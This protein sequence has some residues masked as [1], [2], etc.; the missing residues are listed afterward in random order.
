MAISVNGDS[1]CGIILALLTDSAKP[2]FGDVGSE[3]SMGTPAGSLT[4]QHAALLLLYS[5]QSQRELFEILFEFKVVRTAST[6]IILTIVIVALRCLIIHL[7]PIFLVTSL[8]SGCCFAS[9]LLCAL[10]LLFLV[11]PSFLLFLLRFISKNLFTVGSFILPDLSWGHWS[12]WHLP[13]EVRNGSILGSSHFVASPSPLASLVGLWLTQG[14]CED[15]RKVVVVPVELTFYSGIS[16][17]TYTFRARVH[18]SQLIQV[19]L[20][21]LLAH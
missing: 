17:G 18:F 13:W 10:L 21:V 9:F 14:R 2:V 20:L 16:A 3:L 19:I 11:L 6:F 8:T 7:I 5:L 4:A 15:L 12:R 1:G